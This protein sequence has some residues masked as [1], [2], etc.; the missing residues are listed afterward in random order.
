[1]DGEENGAQVGNIDTENFQLVTVVMDDKP[2]LLKSG[3]LQK[4]S[5][6]GTKV[7]TNYL[8]MCR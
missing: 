5:L 7:S 8:M 1:M 2:A 6:V 4:R 3:H